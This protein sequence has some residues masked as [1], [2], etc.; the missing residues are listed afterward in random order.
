M[1]LA[2][3]RS[4]RPD[5]QLV[6]VSG[7]LSQFASAGRIAPTLQ[8]ALDTWDTAET[9]LTEVWGTFP[10]YREPQHEH[11]RIDWILTTPTVAVLI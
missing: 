10:N 5:G 8:A 3:L 9:R 11:K 1:K 2:T 4:N 7:D 6:V